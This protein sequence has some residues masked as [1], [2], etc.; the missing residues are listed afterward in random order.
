MQENFPLKGTKGNKKEKNT[1]FICGVFIRQNI[2]ILIRCLVLFFVFSF[3]YLF[4]VLKFY[5]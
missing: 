4:D 5:V 1:L 2:E 3:F